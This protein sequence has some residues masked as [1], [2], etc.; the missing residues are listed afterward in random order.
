[1]SAGTIVP[2]NPSIFAATGIY[3]LN[4]L[5]KGKINFTGFWKKW[6]TLS[7]KLFV[8]PQKIPHSWDNLLS[9][10]ASQNLEVHQMDVTTAFLIPELEEDVYMKLPTGYEGACNDGL[11]WK[12]NKSIYGLKQASRAW[13]KEIKSTLISLNFKQPVS[14]PCVFVKCQGH[15]IFFLALYVDDIVLVTNSTT[16]LANTKNSLLAKWNMKDLGEIQQFLGL[17]IERDRQNRIIHISQRLLASEILEDAGLTDCNATR[18][19]C[20]THIKLY[21]DSATRSLAETEEIKFIDYR[22]TVGQLL[23]VSLNPG[24]TCVQQSPSSAA[25]STNLA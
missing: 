14:D 21:D 13:H 2:H 16:E 9:L 1:M 5:E 11:V 23:Y 17:T 6:V 10:A 3:I 8:D 24:Q 15:F 7:L 25:S 4:W 18:S 20:D 12:L 19:P 22:H